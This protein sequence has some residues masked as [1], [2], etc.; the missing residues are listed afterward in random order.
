MFEN[1]ISLTFQVLKN[2]ANLHKSVKLNN[3]FVINKIVKE[4][5]E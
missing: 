5:Y 1:T 4:K 2:F 3:R